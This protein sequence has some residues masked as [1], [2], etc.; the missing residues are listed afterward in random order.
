MKKLLPVVGV[1]ILIG[2]GVFVLLTSKTVPQDLLGEDPKLHLYTVSGES[3]GQ[4]NLTVPFNEAS[5]EAYLIDV[6]LDLDGDG[7]IAESEWQIK[8]AGAYLVQNLKNN[9]WLI[10][11]SKKLAVDGEILVLIHLKKS[12]DQSESAKLEKKTSC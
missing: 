7:Q 3:T 4:L 8:N 10:D 2:V 6:A 5:D 1:L 9:Y 11:E 12:N